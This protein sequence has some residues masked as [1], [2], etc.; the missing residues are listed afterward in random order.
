[1]DNNI[2]AE[3]VPNYITA[4]KHCSQANEN[5]NATDVQI[6]QI[7]SPNWEEEILNNRHNRIIP[8]QKSKTNNKFTFSGQIYKKGNKPLKNDTSLFRHIRY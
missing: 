1:M 4:Q 7:L 6:V 3:F 8:L 5:N 2:L